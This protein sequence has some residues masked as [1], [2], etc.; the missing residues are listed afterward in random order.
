MRLP[1]LALLGCIPLDPLY[2]N[3][4]RVR[5]HLSTW[6][7]LSMLPLPGNYC[8][9]PAETGRMQNSCYC[10][11]GWRILLEKLTLP[12]RHKRP[13]SAEL[14]PSVA[15]C[16]ATRRLGN[17]TPPELHPQTGCH[18]SGDTSKQIPAW[19]LGPGSGIPSLPPNPKP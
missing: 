16:R 5:S 6:L 14:L 4:K 10:R 18:A 9:V 1:K 17:S 12:F 8:S 11:A 7:E 15:P 19:T 2:T 13:A 3:P